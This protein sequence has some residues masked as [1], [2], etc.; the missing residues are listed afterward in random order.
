MARIAVSLSPRALLAAGVSGV[1]AADLALA[2][3]HR[4]TI[5]ARAED[6]T[7][8][9]VEVRGA[10]TDS[11]IAIVTIRGPLEQRGTVATVCGG[12]IDG[13]DLIEARFE[14]AARTVAARGKGEV[15]LHIDSPGGVVTGAFAAARRMR[16]LADKL[17]VRVVSA[18]DG[19]ATSAAYAF[20]LVGEKIYGAAL[21]QT[22]SIGVLL[23]RKSETDGAEIFRSDGDDRKARPNPVEA[24]DDADRAHIQG[25]LDAH[26]EE[27]RTWVSERRKVSVEA[28]RKLK[29]AS[30]FVKDAV[31]LGLVDGIATAHEVIEMAETRAAL[32]TVAEALGLA[33]G[34]SAEQM[35]TKAKAGMAALAELAAAK[36]AV[37]RAEQARVASE[38][39]RRQEQAR[40][41]AAAKRTAFAAEIKAAC[42]GGLLTPAAET[43]VLGLYDAHG[44]G[45]ARAAFVA[46]RAATP[47]VPVRPAGGGPVPSTAQAVEL[48]P[49]ELAHCKTNG[50]DP[51][52]YAEVKA[53]RTVS[54]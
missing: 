21:A 22:A 38:E 46:M 13:Y 25:Y 48:T 34:A 33:P 14:R 3:G 8:K 32:D 42:D 53:R 5:A 9:A 19:I 29:G 23:V 18:I 30:I 45:V 20:A 26:A 15:Q 54:Q 35:A 17:G 51:A 37:A 47:I 7:P 41:E 28:I 36:E 24:L 39:T 4:W 40:I 52:T 10:D 50:L 31:P 2:E 12:A 44:E 1:L 43:A 11:P 49:A 6:L 16:A 27:F